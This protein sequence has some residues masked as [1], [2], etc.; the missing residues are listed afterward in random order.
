MDM[1]VLNLL[2]ILIVFIWVS[3]IFDVAGVTHCL[4][5]FI[6]YIDNMLRGLGV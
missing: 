2:L 6:I 5:G 1:Q 3:L 4:I